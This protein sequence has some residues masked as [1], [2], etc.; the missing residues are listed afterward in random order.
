MVK[1]FF[2]IEKSQNFKALLGNFFSWLQDIKKILAY[3]F[4]YQQKCRSEENSMFF[5]MENQTLNYV[6]SRDLDLSVPDVTPDLMLEEQFE[7]KRQPG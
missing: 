6:V 5:N 1:H 4:F 7:S 3:A 2:H